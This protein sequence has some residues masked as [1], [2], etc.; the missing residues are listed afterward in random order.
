M[1]NTKCHYF[2]AWIHDVHSVALCRKCYYSVVRYQP[3]IM[4][5]RQH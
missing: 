2:E 4:T 1:K 5:E 3:E